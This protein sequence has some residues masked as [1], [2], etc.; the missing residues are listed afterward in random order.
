M[1]GIARGF[2]ASGISRTILTCRSPF[3]RL[4]PMFDDVCGI[5]SRPAQCPRDLRDDGD[6]V[7]ARMARQ[8]CAEKPALRIAH[9]SLGQDQEARSSS[10][11]TRRVSV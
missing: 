11:G 1:I 7:G 6:A 5:V 10:A 4:A 2:I 9:P 8:G 3:S